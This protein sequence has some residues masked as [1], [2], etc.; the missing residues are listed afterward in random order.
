M[1]VERA[2]H[3]HVVSGVFGV[4]YKS[5]GVADVDPH[6]AGRIR[7]F[8]MIIPS[9]LDDAGIDLHGIDGLD[10][11]PQRGGDVVASP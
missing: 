3:D 11:M 1:A 6:L 5:P 2:E 9:H 8:G 7:M 10:S 4:S